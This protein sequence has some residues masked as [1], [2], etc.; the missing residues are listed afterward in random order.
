MRTA[1]CCGVIFALA[2]VAHADSYVR[3]HTRSDGTY[4]QPYHRSNP[5]N[6][7]LD[8]YSTK[9]NYNPYTGE[10]GTVDPYKA[11]STSSG[12]YGSNYLGPRR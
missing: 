6:S 3:G 11:P 4:V 8:N 2:G 12:G 7:M 5:N 9:G 10:K 1:I